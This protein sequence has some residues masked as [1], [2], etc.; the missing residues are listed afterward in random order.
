MSKMS[1][2]SF[3][4]SVGLCCSS[5]LIYTVSCLREQ[6]CSHSIA[7]VAKCYTLSVRHCEGVLLFFWN[8]HDLHFLHLQY[9]TA[10][11]KPVNL[12][13]SALQINTRDRLWWQCHL[14]TNHA[15]LHSNT[16]CL[17]VKIDLKDGGLRLLVIAFKNA[18]MTHVNVSWSGTPP[19][20]MTSLLESNNASLNLIYRLCADEF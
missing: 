13:N 5:V 14:Q 11:F 8:K 7:G 15:A 20:C 1:K 16:A 10:Q 12:K 3:M 4:F 18:H 17:N 19:I 9:W 2:M 6:L